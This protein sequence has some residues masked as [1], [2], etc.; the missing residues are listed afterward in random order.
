LSLKDGDWALD[1]LD[2]LPEGTQPQISV[3]ELIECEA[4]IRKDER[5]IQLAKDVGKHPM[6]ITS[7]SYH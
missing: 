4:I 2:K 6:T 5:V 3:G 1:T 7:V